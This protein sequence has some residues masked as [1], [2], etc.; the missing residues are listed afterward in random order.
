MATTGGSFLLAQPIVFRSRV[1]SVGDLLTSALGPQSTVVGPESLT[2]VA[3][4][5]SVSVGFQ[6][7][8]L[9]ADDVIVGQSCSADVLAEKCVIVGNTCSASGGSV[10][11]VMIGCNLSIGA[12]PGTPFSNAILVG[13]NNS[14]ASG[15]GGDTVI[16]VG[17]NLNHGGAGNVSRNILVGDDNTSSGCTNTGAIGHNHSLTNGVDVHVYGGT[18]VFGAGSNNSVGIGVTVAAGT[19]T[20]LNV[21]LGTTLSLGNDS[22]KCV[23]VGNNVA[24]P[25]NSVAVV[26]LGD[27]AYASNASVAI[28][29]QARVGYGG[30]GGN[31]CVVVGALS[32]IGVSTNNSASIANSSVGNSSGGSLAIVNS[33]IGDTSPSCAAIANSA[34]GNTSNICVAILSSTVGVGCRDSFAA[35]SSTIAAGAQGAIAILGVCS[36]SNSIALSNAT[37]LANEFVAGGV[38]LA[39]SFRTFQVRGYNGVS[40]DLIKAV[41]TPAA[42]STGLS[43]IYNDGAATTNKTLRAAASPP[44]GALLLYVDP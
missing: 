44:V 7:S 24:L 19:N 17:N 36:G 32:T 11:S 23:V 30:V 41:D 1:V 40:L 27:G 12:P 9:G 8:A 5:R 35:V 43:V 28:G 18:I 21:L 10:Q 16:M 14:S 42:G 20:T 15:G 4:N 31:G 33:Q 25:A 6:C 37:A 22:L 38:L 34:V 26:V 13:C 39:T 29:Q 3:A 2:A